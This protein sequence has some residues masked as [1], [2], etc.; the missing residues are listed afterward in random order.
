MQLTISI[1]QQKTTVVE[2]RERRMWMF[3]C[4]GSQMMTSCGISHHF[5]GAPQLILNISRPHPRPHGESFKEKKKNRR[6][7]ASALPG[8]FRVTCCL[9]KPGE[10]CF[11][12]LCLCYKS[13]GVVVCSV[14]SIRRDQRRRKIP[15]LVSRDTKLFPSTM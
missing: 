13:C 9:Y 7:L 8:R 2:T 6:L 15:L 11:S 14:I 1:G 5:S 12:T 4:K 10:F 3:R